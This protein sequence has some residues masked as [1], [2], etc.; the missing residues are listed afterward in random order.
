MGDL[1]AKEIESKGVRV[2]EKRGKN[3]KKMGWLI[4]QYTMDDTKVV[5]NHT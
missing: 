4:F 5:I 3:K 2:K 1:G